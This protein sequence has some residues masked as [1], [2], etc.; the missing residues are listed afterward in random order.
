MRRGDRCDA[1]GN[2]FWSRERK[3]SL[4]KERKKMQGS[5]DIHHQVC[6]NQKCANWRGEG[7]RVLHDEPHGLQL[8]AALH[9][10][11]GDGKIVSMDRGKL[12]IPC[13]CHAGYRS[14]MHPDVPFSLLTATGMAHTL[15]L[16]TYHFMWDRVKHQ[17][18]IGSAN[19]M[20]DDIILDKETP[21]ITLNEWLRLFLLVSVDVLVELSRVQTVYIQR[22]GFLSLAPFPQIDTLVKFCCRS[23]VRMA[24]FE[25]LL[26]VLL[27]GPDVPLGSLNHTCFVELMG[28]ACGCSTRGPA[29]LPACYLRRLTKYNLPSVQLPGRVYLGR[30]IQDVIGIETLTQLVMQFV[31]T[32]EA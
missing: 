6:T 7:L 30:C 10:L 15:P 24:S 14:K 11:A 29:Y 19:G 23:A 31:S 28:C 32:K 12:R 26:S 5:I 4:T 1:C 21:A 27:A 20:G 17:G 18:F 22:S 3:K 9:G 16:R 2:F 8:L 13:L 25:Q